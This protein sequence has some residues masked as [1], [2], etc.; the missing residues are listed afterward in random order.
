[1]IK[2]KG[3]ILY[4]KIPVKEAV[5]C[6]LC[7][8][9]TQIIPGKIKDR[10]FKKGHIIKEEDVPVLLSFRKRQYIYMGEKRRIFT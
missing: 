9:I 7:H 4:E 10:A 3:G 2:V 1:M 6:V 8:D 5:G